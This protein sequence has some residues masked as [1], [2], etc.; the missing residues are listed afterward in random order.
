MDLNTLS[1]IVS[2]AGII[3]TVAAFIWSTLQLRNGVKI[4]FQIDVRKT[5]NRIERNKEKFKQSDPEA[6]KE[7]FDIQDELEAMSQKFL[8]MFGVKR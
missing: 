3:V 6:Y 1:L 2:I 4:A 7:L 5:I 8:S